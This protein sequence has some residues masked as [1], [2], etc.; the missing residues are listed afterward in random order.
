MA[1]IG[2]SRCFLL[3][4]TYALPL[5]VTFPPKPDE[6]V[7]S[8]QVKNGNTILLTIPTLLEQLV[9]ELLSEKNK[10]IELKPLQQL[11]CVEY[12]GAGCPDELCKILRGKVTNLKIAFRFK[13]S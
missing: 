5:C 3:G 1:F 4:C 7:R 10:T 2:S 11:R 8:I 12:G 9:R 13:H 6:L